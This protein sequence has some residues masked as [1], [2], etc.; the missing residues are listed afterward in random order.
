M[1]RTV[2]IAV[3]GSHN[4]LRAAEE[5]LK[6]KAERY[7][8]LSVITPEDSK[9]SIL[10]GT[11]NSE[12]D[13]RDNLAH[14]ISKFSGHQY[15]VVFAHGHPKEK[16]VEAANGGMHEILVIGTRGLSGIKEVV[17]GSVSRHVV[18]QS[19]IHVLVVK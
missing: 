16:I 19:E 14:I 7:T 1:Y 11:G 5:A 3:D 9:E 15:D 6:L 2:L 8:L 4:S 10:H 12:S 18:K 17:M 13:R